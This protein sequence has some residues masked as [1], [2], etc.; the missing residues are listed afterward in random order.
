MALF[1]GN[2]GRQ[3]VFAM[4]FD[5]VVLPENFKVDVRSVGNV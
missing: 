3:V 5:I 2:V 4:Q 1:E